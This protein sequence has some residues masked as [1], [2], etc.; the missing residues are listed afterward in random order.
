MSELRKVAAPRRGR[1]QAVQQMSG[2][3]GE[4]RV[5]GGQVAD[6]DNLPARV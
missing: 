2:P 6:V 3:R 4:E 5:G 1:L